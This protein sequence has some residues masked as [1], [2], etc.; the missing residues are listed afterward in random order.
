MS[1]GT[2]YASLALKTDD[3]VSGVEGARVAM[4]RIGTGALV[5]G[6]AIA[7]GLKQAYDSASSL[8]ETM[9]AAQVVFQA[10]TASVEA[11]GNSAARAYGESKQQAI[12][13]ALVFGNLFRTV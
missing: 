13:A 4:G 12:Q 7:Y 5:A 11:F 6:G 10:S 9:N 3:F 2:W 1:L 8:N